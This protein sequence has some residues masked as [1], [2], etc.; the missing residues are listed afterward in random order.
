[1]KIIQIIAVIFLLQYPN[2]IFSNEVEIIELY[3]GTVDKSL[4]KNLNNTS[5]KKILDENAIDD[6]DQVNTIITNPDVESDS[7]I[8]SLPD[9]WEKTNKEDLEF[10]LN[11]INKI[12]SPI[13][14]NELLSMLDTNSI[15]PIDFNKDDFDNL[16]IKS[17]IKFGEKNKAY[18]IIKSFTDSENLNYDLYYKKFEL[19]YLLSTYNLTEACDYNNEIKNLY[20]NDSDNFFLKIDIF[21][22]L[23]QEKFEEANLLNSLLEETSNVNNEYFQILFEKIKLNNKILKD[24]NNFKI[25]ENEIFLYIAMHRVGNIPLTQNFLEIDPVNVSMP[26]ILSNS[27]NINLRLKAAH[28]A[29]LN[30]ILDN[31]SL[32]ALYQLVDFS[33]DELENPNSIKARI[34]ENI[35]IGMA[36]YYQL[37]NVQI[38]PISRLEAI[39][40]FIEFAEKNNLES[41]AYELSINGLETIEPS[42]EL[43]EFGPQLIKAY[44]NSKNF[45][46]AKKWMIFSENSN[47]LEKN[48]D[49]QSAI[50][51]YNLSNIDESVEFSEILIS[52]LKNLNLQ[53][54]GDNNNLIK[55]Q[56]L[57][58]IFSVIDSENLNPFKLK[59][60]LLDSKPLPSLYLINNIRKSIINNNDPELLINI[61]AS[62]ENSNWN[63][64]HPEHLRLILLGL[65]NYKN[66][67]IFNSLLLE[68]LNENNII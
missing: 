12:K 65:S 9:L 68:I 45:K 31:D 19:N 17:L 53:S 3:D 25:N 7:Y 39:I 64:I 47:S 8:L 24:S 61:I 67:F 60:T 48:D 63:N 2:S 4:L 5:S 46:K 34:K 11:N 55:N 6:S 58:T 28:F 14:R 18:E 41:I 35:E 44:I 66:G 51:L 26:I 57:F 22:L 56:V 10:I 16:M 33:S 52:N 36:Y 21:C 43:S 29:Y 32:S 13:L 27:T 38:L 62:L 50:L 42:N 49:L 40:S 15:P 59:K 20:N 1:M 23:I 54:S 37:I 30:D